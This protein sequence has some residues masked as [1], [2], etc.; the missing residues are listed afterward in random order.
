MARDRPA[1]DEEA[2]ELAAWFTT[3]R[4]NKDIRAKIEAPDLWTPILRARTLVP[5]VQLP[6]AGH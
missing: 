2:E 3:P 4:T 1:V 5:L 6:P